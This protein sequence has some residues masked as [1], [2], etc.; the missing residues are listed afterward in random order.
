MANHLILLCNLGTPASPTQKSIKKFLKEFLMDPR[1]ISLPYLARALLVYGIIS[2]FR[3][4]KTTHAYQSIWTPEGSPLLIYTESLAKKLAIYLKQTQPTENFIVK[5]A[6]RYGEPSIRT[7]LDQLDLNL[8]SKIT[9]LPLYP[10]FSDTTTT[11]VFDA[12][13]DYFKNFKSQQHTPDLNFIHDYH[14]NPLYIQAI[15]D[16]IH[17]FQTQHGKPDLLLFSF[18]GLPEINIQKGDPYLKQSQITVE[19][20]I[21]ALNLKPSEFL[22]TFQSRLGKQKWLEPYTNLTLQQLPKKNIRSVQIICPGFAADCLETLEEINIQNRQLFLDAGG[23][24]FEYIPCL[25][26]QDSHVKLL[27]NLCQTQTTAH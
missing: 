6:M 17:T 7:V 3:S 22:M 11:S 21:R 12:V 9:V 23:Q 24:K 19:K 14:E 13:Q 25:N 10:Q 4:P 20:L 2:P 18:H 16:S 15:Q 5:A 8:F 1:V 26:D 27:A